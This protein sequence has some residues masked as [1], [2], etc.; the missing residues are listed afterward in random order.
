VDAKLRYRS[1]ASPASVVSAGR[2][3]RL[4]LDAPAYGVAVGQAAVLDEGDA[5]VGAGIIS[6]TG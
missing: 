6:A 2:G 4:E 3:F 5:V 1:P